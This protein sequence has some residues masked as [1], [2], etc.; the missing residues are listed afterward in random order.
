MN[1][2]FNKSNKN[3]TNNQMKISQKLK[4]NGKWQVEYVQ[5]FMND[6]FIEIRL[7][8]FMKPSIGC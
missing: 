6:N 2:C 1:S 7:F 8:F 3:L 4:Q 5:Q